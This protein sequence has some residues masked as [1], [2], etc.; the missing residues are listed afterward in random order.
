MQPFDTAAPNHYN[1]QG[2]PV[3]NNQVAYQQGIHNTQQAA[4]R[5][6]IAQQLKNNISAPGQG[7]V[8]LFGFIAIVGSIAAAYIVLQADYYG[9][10]EKVYKSMQGTTF[11]PEDLFNVGSGSCKTYLIGSLGL[12]IFLGIFAAWNLL[13]ILFACCGTSCCLIFQAL[14]ALI[15]GG[16]A[17][18][19]SQQKCS[20]I[21]AFTY[22]FGANNVPQNPWPYF[23]ALAVA[24][25]VSCFLNYS[26]SSNRDRAER[27]QKNLSLMLAA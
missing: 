17:A 22:L 6:M 12:P 4:Q 11:K 16:L 7:L 5:N 18:F 26:W 25:L 15:W 27:D 8:I 13:A 9:I 14:M 21:A 20:G 19:I 1:H 23:A 24:S 10:M 3:Y 2:I